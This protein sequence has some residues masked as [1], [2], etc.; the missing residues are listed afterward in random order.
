[1]NEREEDRFVDY[2]E[3]DAVVDL[4][5]EH[6]PYATGYDPTD[7]ILI[8]YVPFLDRKATRGLFRAFYVPWLFDDKLKWSQYVILLKE[9]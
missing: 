9:K 7:F 8:R 2:K 1:M 4:W 3:C 6:S 5:E